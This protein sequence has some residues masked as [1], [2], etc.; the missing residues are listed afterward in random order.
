MLMV[1]FIG[2]HF[3]LGASGG[4]MNRNLA[5]VLAVFLAAGVG[6]TRRVAHGLLPNLAI[7]V[8]C[9]SEITLV[10]CDARVNPPKCKS[11]RVKYRSG[12]EELVVGAA[13]FAEERRLF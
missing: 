12:C 13:D 1:F 6:C 9:A 11:A 3:V 2:S 7:P 8:R 4:F 5:L 10:G